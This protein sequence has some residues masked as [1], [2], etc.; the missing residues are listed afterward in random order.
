MMQSRW[1]RWLSGVGAVVLIGG[2]VLANY[3]GGIMP[4][5]AHDHQRDAYNHPNPFKQILDKLNEILAKLNKVE[6]EAG[7]GI[8]RCGGTPRSVGVAL[9]RPGGLWRRG[10]TG[11]QHRP[12]VGTIAGHDHAQSSHGVDARIIV[13][14]RRSE[15][16]EGGGCPH[17]RN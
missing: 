16:R 7:R 3:G 17:C 9:Y 12:G 13:P 15:A 4:A 14:T 6:V 11:Q 8:R 1:N 10:C 2:L 5:E